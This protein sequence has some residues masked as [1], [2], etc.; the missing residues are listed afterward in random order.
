MEYGRI[1]EVS[2]H[3]REDY[4]FLI[5]SAHRKCFAISYIAKIRIYI[6]MD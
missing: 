5:K 2:G 6:I 3:S 4:A 1:I